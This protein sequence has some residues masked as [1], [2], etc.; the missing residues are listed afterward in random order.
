MQKL[1]KVFAILVFASLGAFIFFLAVTGRGETNPP[2]AVERYYIKGADLSAH[3]GTVDFNALRSAGIEFVFLK[4]SEGSS[5]KDSRFDA[6]HGNARRAGLKTGAY[7]FFRFDQPGYMQALNLMHSVRG[8]TLDLPLAIDV[9]Q[10][11]NPSNRHTDGIVEQIRDMKSTLETYGYKVI[12]YTN[13]D[14][15]RQF[16]KNHLEDIPLW[17]CSFNNIDEDV[18]WS[19]WQYS[20]RGII[21]GVER[22]VDLNVFNGTKQEWDSLLISPSCNEQ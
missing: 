14:G 19:F 16:V 9:E 1:I 13:K 6:N 10:W 5:F 18:K 21:K 8:K 17:L 2:S 3:N 22:L 11:T 7:H 4:A 12:I 15:Y 20:H